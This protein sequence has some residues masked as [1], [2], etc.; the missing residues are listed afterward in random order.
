L[1]L[2]S[3]M[4]G[5]VAGLSHWAPWLLGGG[6]AALVVAV[7]LIYLRS[8][9]VRT[10][11]RRARAAEWIGPTP[12]IEEPPVVGEAEP[13]DA[14][15]KRSEAGSSPSSP[16][17]LSFRAWASRRG[18]VGI[19]RRPGPSTPAAAASARTPAKTSMV[20]SRPTRSS[21]QP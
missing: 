11:A 17:S 8:R 1:L 6:A 20:G 16:A 2:I 4:L 18:A 15:A 19:R 14:A 9:R 5:D 7:L 13:Q 10:I 21:P 3:P 12:E